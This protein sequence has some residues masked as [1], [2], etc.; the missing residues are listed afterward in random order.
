MIVCSC[1]GVTDGELRRA[2]GPD[3]EGQCPAGT[4]CGNCLPAVHAISSE[5]SR[6]GGAQT[7]GRGDCD[8][9]CKHESRP[10]RGN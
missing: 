1:Y 8:A 6:A 10:T 4:G 7:C 3:G 9:G 2:L 5:C